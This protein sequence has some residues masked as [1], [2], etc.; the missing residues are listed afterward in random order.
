MPSNR[1]NQVT[2]A[3]PRIVTV[4][5]SS[6]L[7]LPANV[8]RNGLAIVNSSSG[9]ISS[10]L[11]ASQ[12]VSGTG[13]VGTAQSNGYYEGVVLYVNVTAA[14]TSLTFALESQDPVSGAWGA[15]WTAAA[16]TTTGLFIYEM[17]PGASSSGG[18]A[19]AFAQVLPYTWRIR[20]TAITGTFT[21]SIGYNLI[22]ITAG[23]GL[24][25]S[26]GLGQAAVNGDD[27]VLFPGQA[28]DGFQ[29]DDLWTGAVYAISPVAGAT[30][31]VAEM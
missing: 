12:A 28:W 26:L 8:S 15:M 2:A 6:G 5:T 18:L 31:S 13:P 16:I 11:L 3:D 1:S 27:I 24:P 22:P 21:M 25:V 30:L 19:G 17:F 9:H 4:T 10:T 29:G 23:V 20:V 7:V 14:G